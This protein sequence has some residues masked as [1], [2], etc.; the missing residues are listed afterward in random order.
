MISHALIRDCIIRDS[1]FDDLFVCVIHD[2]D[3]SLVEPGNVSDVVGRGDSL[4]LPRGG[5]FRS[6][7]RVHNTWLLI[8][9]GSS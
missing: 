6:H 7:T 9:V 2:S 8:A 4:H 5:H 1:Y 3:R